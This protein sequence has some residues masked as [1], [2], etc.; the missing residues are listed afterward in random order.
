MKY[1]IAIAFAVGT[2]AAAVR[3]DSVRNTATDEKSVNK[4]SA[5]WIEAWNRHDASSMAGLFTE[6]GDLINPRGDVAR[7]RDQILKL[8]QTEQA[9]MLKGS[10][11]AETCEPAKFLDADVAQLDCEFSL[12]GIAGPEPTQRGHGT[13]V[14]LH[15]GTRWSIAS[16]R[17]MVPKQIPATSAASR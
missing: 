1:A 3:A 14:L 13:A 7:G 4:L 17:A 12:T 10:T 16:M 6:R 5:D 15:E 2:T 9:G 11:M 8:F